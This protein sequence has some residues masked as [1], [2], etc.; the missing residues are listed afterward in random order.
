M[1]TSLLRNA[2]TTV[3]WN[4]HVQGF[5]DDVPSAHTVIQCN[6]RLA[7]WSKQFEDAD[8]GNPALSFIREMQAAG[9]YAAALTSL[10]LY[11]PAAA[12]IRT[13]LETALYYTYFRTHPTELGTLVR[14]EDYY[15]QRA[16]II[17]YHRKHT[18]NFIQFQNCFG[19]LGRMQTWY[20]WISSIIHGQIPGVWT[21]HQSLSEIKH[22][23]E[24]MKAV[25]EAFSQGEALVHDLFLC[26]VG[27]ELWDSFSST[28]KRKLLRGLPG[29]TKTT[30]KLDSA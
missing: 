18:P 21:T 8:K 16:D 7:I 6:L 15:L 25:I 19:L 11:K 14:S 10:A 27:V 23:P 30:L 2:L 1:E 3:D 28:A 5:L 9:H 24:N 12:A 26:T 4:S 29:E 20:S 22:V 13:V 17:D